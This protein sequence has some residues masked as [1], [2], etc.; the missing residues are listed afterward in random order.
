MMK[1]SSAIIDMFNKH[2]NVYSCEHYRGNF[3]CGTLLSTGTEMRIDKSSL[4]RDAT[5]VELVEA[6]IIRYNERNRICEQNPVPH[7]MA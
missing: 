7:K 1:F 3:V 2:N 4:V 6:F 5:L